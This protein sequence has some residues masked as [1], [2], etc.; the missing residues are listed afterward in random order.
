MST[1]ERYPEMVADEREHIRATDFRIPLAS[2]AGADCYKRLDMVVRVH[3]AKRR[4]ELFTHGG[5]TVGIFSDFDAAVAAYNEF[6][7]LEPPTPPYYPG[8]DPDRLCV[9]GRPW[10]G[11]C[12]HCNGYNRPIGV[13]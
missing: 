7:R 3:G 9:H 1:F 12:P 4:F 5:T 10:G 13:R 2:H 6:T 11:P 8:C